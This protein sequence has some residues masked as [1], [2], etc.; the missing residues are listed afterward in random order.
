MPESAE[1]IDDQDKTG[2]FREENVIAEKLNEFF[3][4]IHAHC[5]SNWRDLNTTA[6]SG[7]GSSEDLSK[8]DH[9]QF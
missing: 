9:K 6:F 7:E 1:L 2:A 4:L 5:K 3:A 8:T